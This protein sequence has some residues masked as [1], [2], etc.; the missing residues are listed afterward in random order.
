MATMGTASMNKH[1]VQLK[2]IILRHRIV[3]EMSEIILQ[4]EAEEIV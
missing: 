4:I 3:N 2:L 1:S